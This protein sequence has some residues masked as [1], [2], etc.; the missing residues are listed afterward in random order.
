MI[1][2]VSGTIDFGPEEGMTDAT[3]QKLIQLS[4]RHPDGTNSTL[5]SAAVV[6]QLLTEVE[7]LKYE[8]R[9]L[10]DQTLTMML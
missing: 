1:R 5:F 4:K 7:D 3:F 2:T 10:L 8:I 6:Q 9:I